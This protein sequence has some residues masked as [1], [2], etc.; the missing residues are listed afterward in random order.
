MRGRLML[1]LAAAV[2]AAQPA[3]AQTALHRFDG[4]FADE[5][6]T[7]F[8]HAEP[9]A[10]KG[11]A[12]RLARTGAFD[13]LHPFILRG[14]PAAG[15]DLTFDTLMAGDDDPHLRRCLLCESV[16]VAAD[17]SSV[18]FVL[19]QQ[20]RFRDG[21]P[22]RASDLA[23]TF[24]TLI[25][26]GHPAFR[27]HYRGVAA[28]EEIDE[29]SVRFVFGGPERDLP[30]LL[31]ELPVL[32]RAW[33]EGRDFAR[34][35]ASP[36]LGSGPYH[37][38]EVEHGRSVTYRRDP[39]YWGRDLPVNR[40]RHNFDTIRIDYYRDDT[41][42]LEAFKA[43]AADIR[44]ERNAAIWAAGYDAPVRR[45]EVPEDRVSGMHGFAM[46]TRRPF[47]GDRRVR[48]ALAY[49]FD[50][51]WTNRVLFH[52]SQQRLRSYF[53]NADL[54]ARGVPGEAELEALAPL[55]GRV[56]D[57]V[58]AR[59]YEPPRTAGTGSWREQRRA[60]TRLLRE[61]GYRVRDGQLVDRAGTPVAFEIL[62]D[63]PQL[64]R[65]AL[66]YAANLRRLGIAAEIRTVD[67]AQYRHR[68]DR[69]DFDMTVAT[70]GQSEAPGSEQRGYW[71][72]AEAAL[73]GSLNIAGIRDAAVD[74]LVE[75]VIAAPDA[76]SLAARTRALDRVL[77]WGHYVVPLGYSKVDRIAWWDRFGRPASSPRAGVDLTFWWAQQ[78][79]STRQASR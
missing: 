49:A 2:A 13:S 72:S 11:G 26:A 30:L 6:F 73:P 43:G 35:P 68:L 65:V 71:T 59:P 45:A 21:T 27:V 29:R 79:S 76:A 5:G 31:G 74:A 37:V 67:S 16:R 57:E 24:R 18:E 61:A 52:G 32:P 36:V 48:A 7:Q 3:W 34:A 12:V 70:F 56:P 25:S 50:F 66:A 60:A 1:V 63:D 44:F 33:W 17:R 58:F 22:V 14:V 46:N 4:E 41:A 15:L 28:V 77:Q 62:L 53:N 38:D 78:R 40:G 54:A 64:E 42:A 19:H 75:L 23:W 69:F 55:R 39:H 10:P 51:E 47:F 8:S 9:H 20:A